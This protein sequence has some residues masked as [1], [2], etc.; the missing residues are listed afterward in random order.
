MGWSKWQWIGVG[1]SGQEHGLV[2][3]IMK[4]SSK[5]LGKMKIPNNN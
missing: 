4:Y 3:P 2:K 1:G 5:Y